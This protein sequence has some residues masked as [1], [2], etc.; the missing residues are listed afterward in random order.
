M[1]NWECESEYARDSLEELKGVATLTPIKNEGRM[2]TP[3][4]QE[5]LRK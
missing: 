2:I 3:R 1:K 5:D 4:G